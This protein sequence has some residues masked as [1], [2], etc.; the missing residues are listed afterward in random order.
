MS[1]FHHFAHLK[2]VPIVKAGQYVEVGQLLGYVGA[3]GAASGSHLHYEVMRGKPA[4][5]RFYPN[6][7]A[8][9]SVERLYEN[10]SKF[11]KDGFPADFTYDGWG[12]LE[13]TGKVFHPGIDINSPADDGKPVYTPV[14]GRVVFAEGISFWKRLGRLVLP[15]YLNGGWG[16]HLWIEEDHVKSPFK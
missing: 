5:W 16:N 7:W 4:S 13:W 3:T 6:G 12:F 15:Q 1:R 2:H 10:P 8:K 11:I 14:P 9:K